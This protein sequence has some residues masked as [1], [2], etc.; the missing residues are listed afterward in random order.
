MDTCRAEYAPGDTGPVRGDQSQS[1]NSGLPG[2]SALLLLGVICAVVLILNIY[3][4]SRRDFLL[5]YDSANYADVAENLTRGRGFTIDFMLHFFRRY[6]AVS[7][8]EDRRLSIH[9]AVIALFF[10]LFGKSAFAAKLPNILMGSLVLPLT[11]YVLA[12]SL[13][14]GKRAAFFAAVS[15]IFAGGVLS[16]THTA[17]ADLLFTWFFLLYV[18]S[19]YRGLDD[20]RWLYGAGIFTGLCYLA[21][22]QGLILF[23]MTLVYYISVKGMV[24]ALKNRHLLLSMLAAAIVMSPFLMRNYR[25]YNDPFYTTIRYNAGYDEY[26]ESSPLTWWERTFKV[27]WDAGP[28][29]YRREMLGR[30]P[31]E[32]AVKVARQLRYAGRRLGKILWLSL[33]SVVVFHR[34]KKVRNLWFLVLTYLLVIS[35]F[36]AFHGRYEIPLVPVLLILMWGGIAA[37]VEKAAGRISAGGVTRRGLFSLEKKAAFALT[38]VFLLLAFPDIR[39]FT[40]NLHAGPHRFQGDLIEVARWSSENLDKSSVVMTHDPA[41]FNFYSGMRAVQIPYDEEK[42]IAAVIDHYGVTH[43]VPWTLGESAYR[44]VLKETGYRGNINILLLDPSTKY[45]NLSAA[46]GDRGAKK[47][48]GNGDLAVFELQ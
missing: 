22:T 20:S 40:A 5:G 14:I 34:R 26:F 31:A 7:H 8:P 12:R 24:S 6:P 30:R 35:L 3:H 19:L 39:N 33:L 36:F 23:P 38:A 27:Y 28:P 11:T 21:K 32:L 1:G 44:R 43:V 42:Q 9:S 41:L 29:D 2:H 45:S 4:L 10:L 18:Y 17:M 46:A 47:L 15:V 25:L 48:Y 16:Q 37:V 13:R